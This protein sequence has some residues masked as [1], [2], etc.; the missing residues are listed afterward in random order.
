ME[1]DKKFIEITLSEFFKLLFYAPI[2]RP[3][4]EDDYKFIKF[5]RKDKNFKYKKNGKKPSI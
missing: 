5:M 1:K 4:I 2:E 3:T